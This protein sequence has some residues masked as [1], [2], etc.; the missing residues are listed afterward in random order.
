MFCWYIIDS[1]LSMVWKPNIFNKRERILLTLKSLGV[2]LS[3]SN[4]NFESIC[5]NC[6]ASQ[7]RRTW[8][9]SIINLYWHTWLLQ[10]GLF[11]ISNTNQKWLFSAQ[12]SRL[13]TLVSFSWIFIVE[14]TLWG[15]YLNGLRVVLNS[16]G[17][18]C[19]TDRT[20]S[21]SVLTGLIP[22]AATNSSFSISRSKSRL[23]PQGQ[24]YWYH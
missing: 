15:L 2:F 1:S 21:G 4:R 14:Y 19:R 18:Y 8:Q 16:I 6:Y 22:P 11:L 10:T 7:K 3:L 20:R 17:F 13:K 5:Q 24:K 23:R 12:R 9:K